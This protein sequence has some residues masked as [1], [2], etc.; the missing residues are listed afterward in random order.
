MANDVFPVVVIGGGLAGLTA[1]VHL[2]ARDCPPLVLEADNDWAGGRLSG[3]EPDEFEY[4]GRNWSFPTEHGIHALWGAYDNMRAM[5]DRFLEIEL[6]PSEGEEWINR[7]GQ[8]VTAIE[9]GNAVRSRWVPAPLHYLQ[10][11]LRPHFWRT[12]KLYD[13]LSLPGYIV[14]MFWTLGFDPIKEHQPLDGL[15]MKEYFRG[16]TPNLRATFTGLGTNLLASNEEDINLTAFIA[17]IRFYTMLRRDAWRLDYLPANSGESL[18]RPLCCKIEALGGKVFFG[19]RAR[20]LE[21]IDDCWHIRFEDAGLGGN[22]TLKAA[23]VILALD[24]KSAQT[25]LSESAGTSKEVE[26]L[27]FPEVTRNSTCRIWFDAKPREGAPGGMFTGDFV[28]DN[29]FWLHR[30]HEEFFEWG[31]VA[32]G[33]M[34]EVH[35]YNR[36]H[37]LDQPDALIKA[38][39]IKEV[40]MAFPELKGHVVHSTLRHNGYNQTQFRVPTNDSLH[41]DTPWHDVYACGDWIGY[42]TPSLWMERC[43]VT[44]MAAANRVL[45]AQGLEEFEILPARPPEPLARFISADMVFLRKLVSPIIFGIAKMGRWLDRRFGGG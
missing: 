41:V 23:N 29:F 36:D 24:P 40:L 27:T 12:I 4:E 21:R 31:E 28:M 42:P 32:G 10:L 7:R 11:L 3:G 38:L 37:V 13:F 8:K 30:I 5:L 43:T 6:R 19:G 22:R 14:S 25:L 9:A 16:W 45:E 20:H 39:V 33:S 44:G 1:A 15:K 17:A 34:I 35:L 26:F 18:I 2:A